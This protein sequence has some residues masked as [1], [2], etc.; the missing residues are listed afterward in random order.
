LV[1]LLAGPPALASV[2]VRHDGPHPLTLGR[3]AVLV[4]ADQRLAQGLVPAGADATGSGQRAGIP[5]HWCGTPTAEDRPG[6]PTAQYVKV[7]YAH[8]KGAPSRFDRLA[9]HIQADVQAIGRYWAVQTAGA[10]TVRFDLGTE[11]GPL[12]ADIEVWEMPRSAAYYQ[13]HGGNPAQDFADAHAPAYGPKGA[14]ASCDDPAVGHALVYVDSAFPD[15]S[16]GGVGYGDSSDGRP[17]TRNANNCGGGIAL[18]KIGREFDPQGRWLAPNTAAHELLHAFGAGNPAAPHTTADGHCSDERDVFCYDDDGAGP[19]RMRL[20][21]RSNPGAGPIAEGLD[22]GRDDYF[23]LPGQAR[24]SYLPSGWNVYDLA[25]LVPCAEAGPACAA[26]PADG[27]AG[28]TALYRA[29][30]V[31]GDRGPHTRGLVTVRR[32]AGGLAAV[33]VTAQPTGPRRVRLHVTVASERPGTE[34][35]WV[36]VQDRCRRASLKTGAGAEVEVETFTVRR[37]IAARTIPVRLAAIGEGRAA[38]AAAPMRLRS[39][40]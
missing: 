35:A 18:V 4:A 30:D 25:A 24:G 21:C 10:K 23:A 9:S 22:C 37:S 15:S 33:T 31:P 1:V 39:A 17:G 13:T 20:A 3:H 26:V 2:G 6:T 32:S 5:D 34:K 16:F 38:T 19:T 27:D 29:A 28:D 8:P 11:C 40:R 12:Y 7:V 14:S 36:C